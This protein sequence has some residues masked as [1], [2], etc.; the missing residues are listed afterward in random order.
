MAGFRSVISTLNA[1][2]EDAA[3]RA[4]QDLLQIQVG[5]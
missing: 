3:V 1:N 4:R 2:G 5:R